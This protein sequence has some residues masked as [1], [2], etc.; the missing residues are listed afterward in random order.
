MPPWVF[1]KYLG[2]LWMVAYWFKKLVS[3]S[4]S[5]MDGIFR[6]LV[7][8]CNVFGFLVEVFEVFGMNVAWKLSLRVKKDSK[9]KVSI[10]V[11]VS[12]FVEINLML[13]EF[14]IVLVC[15]NIA[16][17]QGLPNTLYIRL[18]L[19]RFFYSYTV[20]TGFKVVEVM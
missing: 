19:H 2:G 3:S 10:M 15:L 16:F 6:K 14:L 4:S 20:L 9:Q 17:C 18:C 13:V 1:V 12:I 8:V 5:F 7:M 11:A